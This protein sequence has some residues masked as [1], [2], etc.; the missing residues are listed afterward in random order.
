ML[1]RSTAVEKGSPA[2]DAGIQKGMLVVGLGQERG[3]FF[4]A[5]DATPIVEYTNKVIYLKDGEIA[6]VENKELTVKSIENVVQVPYV[7]ELEL[8]LEQLEKGGYPHFML[9]EIMEEPD[10]VRNTLRGRLLALAAVAALPAIVVAI[11]G[12]ALYR[13]R[14]NDHLAQRLTHETE[15]AAAENLKRLSRRPMAVAEAKFDWTDDRRAERPEWIAAFLEMKTV[16]HPIG[17]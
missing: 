2:A 10:A 8:S 16:W 1:F 17:V 6:I 14:L 9:K 3:E 11:A 13:D 15:S 5:S 4:F 12:V 7:Q